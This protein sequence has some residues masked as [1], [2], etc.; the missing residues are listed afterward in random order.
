MK[1]VGVIVD[2]LVELDNETYRKHVVFE[3]WK[4]E[5]YVVVLRKNYG[6]IVAELLLYNKFRGDLEN[7]GP[8]FNPYDLC[9]ANTIKFASKNQW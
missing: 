3:N 1:I 5:I 4:K 9:V 7:I 2:I 6:M 8:E